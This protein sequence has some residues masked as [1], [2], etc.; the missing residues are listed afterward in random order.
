MV[1][2][3]DLWLPST[4]SGGFQP[5]GAH[6]ADALREVGKRSTKKTDSPDK[7]SGLWTKSG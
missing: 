3:K 7:H 5:P 4:K 2:M 6:I 1:E